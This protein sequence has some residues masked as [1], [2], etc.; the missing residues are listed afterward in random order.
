MNLYSSEP[1][2]I[3]II[4]SIDDIAHLF[5]QIVLVCSGSIAV[6]KVNPRS[7]VL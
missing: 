4:E 7:Q 6:R 5:E 3:K 1:Y 2:T